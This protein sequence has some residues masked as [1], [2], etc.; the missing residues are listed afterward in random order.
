MAKILPEEPAT[1][2]PFR[3]LLGAL[4]GL[5]ISGVS[6]TAIGQPTH[7][8]IL[9]SSGNTFWHILLGLHF[10]FLIVLTISALRVLVISSSKVQSVKSRARLGMLFVILGIVCGVLVLHKIHPGIFLFGMALAFLL[11]GFT[12][13]PMTGHRGKKD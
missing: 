2:L 6:M 7:S 12:Y 11:I 10:I 13:G 4:I 3:P 5:F 8:H 9:S 1:A